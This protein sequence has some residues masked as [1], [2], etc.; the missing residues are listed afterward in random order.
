MTSVTFWI[1]VCYHL[2]LSRKQHEHSQP[3]KW[4]QNMSNRSAQSI[5]VQNSLVNDISN[6]SVSVLKQHPVVAH[7]QPVK[8]R[9]PHNYTVGTRTHAFYHNAIPIK[10]NKICCPLYFRNHR[11]WFSAGLSRIGRVCFS[12]VKLCIGGTL[13]PYVPSITFSSPFINLLN[14]SGFYTY[15]QVWHSK[16][17]LDARF[18]L[19]VL[20]GTQNKQRFCF[21]H[22]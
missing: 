16:I 20:L 19:S 5:T 15:H 6:S 4:Q 11:T 22:H 2:L 8:M 10:Q 21:I 12:S 18:A 1:R 7:T 17:L 3:Q 9:F 13:M 14:P